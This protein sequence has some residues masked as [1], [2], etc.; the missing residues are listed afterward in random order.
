MEI[1][2]R[3]EEK[4][5]SEDEERPAESWARRGRSSRGRTQAAGSA[6]E[7]ETFQPW[8]SCGSRRKVELGVSRGRAVGLGE[9]SSWESSGREVELWVSAKNRAEGLR[10]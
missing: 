6:R 10:A 5:K 7:L 8:A 2:I 4:K 3:L 9:E 1:R